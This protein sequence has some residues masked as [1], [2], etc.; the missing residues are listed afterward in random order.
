MGIAIDMLEIIQDIQALL[1]AKV[2][3]NIWQRIRTYRYP[4][5]IQQSG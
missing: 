1:V 2:L 3:L 4:R 5:W